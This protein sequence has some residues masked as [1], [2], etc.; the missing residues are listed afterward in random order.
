MADAGA[1]IL[2]PHMGLTTKGTIGAVD[3][4][5]ARRR[6]AASAGDARRRAARED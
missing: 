2:I 1:D 3:G 4:R 5:Y 6:G